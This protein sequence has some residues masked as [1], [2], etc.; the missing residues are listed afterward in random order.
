MPDALS[1]YAMVKPPLAIAHEIDCCRRLLDIESRYGMARFHL[2]VLPLGN[3]LHIA[4]AQ[5]ERLKQVMASVEVEPFRVALDTLERNALIGKGNGGIRLL[6]QAL[7]QA[8]IAA[9]LPVAAY[10]ARPHVSIAYDAAPERKLS[11]PTIAWT[12]E[13]FLLIRSGHGHHEVLGQWPLKSRQ[14]KLPF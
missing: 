11:V 13:D 1:L 8:L 6:R 10:D 2:T 12:A 7:K 5:L 14:G 4:T 9:G 3:S